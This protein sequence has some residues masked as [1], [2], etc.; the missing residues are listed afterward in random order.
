MLIELLKPWRNFGKS[1]LLDLDQGLA[2]TL[3]NQKVAKRSY[4]DT[5]TLV[6]DAGGVAKIK[7]KGVDTQKAD[8]TMKPSKKALM[9]PPE[10]K[11]V[12]KRQAATK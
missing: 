5:S 8:K 12:T 1:Q 2:L 9:H 10:N 3:L 7:P 4:T 6:I 11:M